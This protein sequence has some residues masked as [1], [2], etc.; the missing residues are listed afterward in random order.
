[1]V[2]RARGIFEGAGIGLLT[3]GNAG[4]LIASGTMSDSHGEMKGLYLLIGSVIGGGAGL[5]GGALIGAIYGHAN[6][7]LSLYKLKYPQSEFVVSLQPTTIQEGASMKKV[8]PFLLLASIVGAGVSNAQLL[9][10]VKPGLTG[11]SAQF[12]LKLAG[13]MVFGGLEYLRTSATTEESGMR[14][15]YYYNNTPPYNSYY[16]LEPYKDNHE[17]S[18]NVYAPFVGAKIL[19]GGRESGKTGAYVTALIGK[20]II[21]GSSIDNGKESESTQK[22]FDNLSTWM[23]QAG[24]GAEYFFS[25]EFSIGGEFGLR[26]FLVNYTEEDDEM[27]PVYDYQT[28]TTQY[29]KTSSKYN[30]DLGLGIT[31]STIVL[32]YYF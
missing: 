23:F 4:L 12:G 13:L 19:L 32:N 1:M 2:N 28:G 11:N 31:Y 26:A 24:F 6:E 10:G 15:Q 3:G 18:L 22:M 29:Y 17:T 14:L 5:L 8:I 25:E 27:T 21:S 20:P 30:L 9:F 7:C 16:R